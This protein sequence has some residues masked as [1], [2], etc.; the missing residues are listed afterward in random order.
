MI[1]IYTCTSI[2]DDLDKSLKVIP[3]TME[4]SPWTVSR[5]T[6]ELYNITSYSL[7]QKLQLAKVTHA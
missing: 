7:L 1:M 4:T 5:K 3:A 6:H 2:F